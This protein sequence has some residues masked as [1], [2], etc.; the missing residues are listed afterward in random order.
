MVPSWSGMRSITTGQ[1]EGARPFELGWRASERA[2][3]E[4]EIVNQPREAT[5]RWRPSTVDDFDA[6][7]CDHY[8]YSLTGLI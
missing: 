8:E 1:A 2:W 4:A 6:T 5:D 3:S 7:A